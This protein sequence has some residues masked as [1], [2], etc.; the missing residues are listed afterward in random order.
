M[1]LSGKKKIEMGFTGD[2]EVIE[3]IIRKKDLLQNNPQDA[4]K[5]KTVVILPGGGQRGILQMGVALAFEKLHATEGIDEVLGISSGAGVGMYWLSGEAA[6]GARVS[7]DELIK[8]HFISYLHPLRIM[9]IKVLEAILRK[10]RPVNLEYFQKQRTELLIGATDYDTGKEHYLS[11]KKMKDPISGIIA[12]VSIPVF[13]KNVV[14]IQKHFYIDGGPG[15]PLPIS[16]AIEKLHATDILVILT[17]TLDYRPA[18]PILVEF[19]LRSTIYHT[20][21]KG[22]REDL[23][24]YDQRYNSE[25]AYFMG[26]KDIPRNVRLAAIY[27]KVMPIRKTTK[28]AKILKEVLFAS[29]TFA[30]DFLRTHDL[31]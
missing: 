29:E 2:P 1:F 28:N 6:T 27:P 20:L 9:N 10:I 18:F 19:L 22:V 31:K 8:D 16:Y 4:K 17:R 21:S 26:E 5:L 13:A 11:V 23:I 14:E 3:N 12:S 7:F 24:N 15:S 30:E 25:L